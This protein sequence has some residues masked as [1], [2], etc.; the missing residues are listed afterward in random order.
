MRKVIFDLNG[1]LVVGEYP[2][3]EYV[4]EEELGLKRVGKRGFRLED[5]R[6]VARGRLTLTDLVAEAFEVKDPEDVLQDAI[7]IYISKVRLRPEAKPVLDSLKKKYPLILCSDTTGVAREVIRKFNLST[8]FSAI[9]LSC[10]I[11]FL[12]S[13]EGFWRTCLSR[14]GC[15]NPKDLFVVGDSPATDVY[16]PRRLGLHTILIET[17]IFSVDSWVEQPKGLLDEEPEYRINSL[18]EVLE[19]L[20]PRP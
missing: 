17:A 5:L 20:E 9:F 2:S 13:E 14:I 7:R 16:W 18:N 19:I 12:K 4:F 6:E 8:Y 11:G 3:W 15:S 1:T 10:E